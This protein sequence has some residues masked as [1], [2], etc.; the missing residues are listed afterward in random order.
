MKYRLINMTD[1]QDQTIIDKIIKMW[2]QAG[3]LPKDANPLNR[4]K[5]VIVAAL[6]ENDNVVGV[7][8]AYSFKPEHG[9]L[10][11]KVV[12]PMRQFILSAHRNFELN[13]KMLWLSFDI[14]SNNTIGAEGIILVL[15]NPK[16]TRKGYK[17]R[18][19]K[20]GFVQLPAPH[21]KYEVMYKPFGTKLGEP[22]S[23]D[24]IE[25]FSE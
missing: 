23:E 13:R 3:V 24:L 16:L 20:I 12:F 2:K 6:D 8:T 11:G 22:L 15:E 17:K 14:L 21:M 4:V 5:Q 18:Y 1:N 7:N 10:E 19:A 25:T 9:K